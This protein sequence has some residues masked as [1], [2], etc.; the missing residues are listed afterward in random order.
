MTWTTTP[1]ICLGGLYRIVFYPKLSK[2]FYSF[3]FLPLRF[4]KSFEKAWL[5][6]NIVNIGNKTG[7]MKEFR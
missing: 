1:L 5:V 2:V 6:S 7:R 3:E 4:Y